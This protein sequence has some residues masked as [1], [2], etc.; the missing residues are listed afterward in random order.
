MNNKGVYQTAWM[1]MLDLYLCCSHTPNPDD[2]FSRVEVHISMLMRKSL[3]IKRFTHT[4]KRDLIKQ[5]ENFIFESN[6]IPKIK[7][8]QNMRVKL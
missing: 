4:C 2:R 6:Y 7:I 5:M 8:S 1:Y 3:M